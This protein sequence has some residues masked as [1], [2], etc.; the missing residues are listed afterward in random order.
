MHDSNDLNTT[1]RLEQISDLQRQFGAVTPH[2]IWPFPP[3]AFTEKQGAPRRATHGQAIRESR[4]RAQVAPVLGPGHVGP[5]HARNIPRGAQNLFGSTV[6]TNP[7]AVGHPLLLLLIATTSRATEASTVHTQPRLGSA[8]RRDSLSTV[9]PANRTRFAVS[10]TC[11][12]PTGRLPF[13]SGVHAPETPPLGKKSNISVPKYK[14]IG[15][16]YLKKIDRSKW[17]KIVIGWIVRVGE[18]SRWWRVVM[19]RECWW[20]NCY[21]L[22]QIPRAKIYY[23]LGRRKYMIVQHV[24]FNYLIVFYHLGDM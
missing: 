6:P 20:R 21:I 10:S 15:H 23:I 19:G 11:R 18:K 22:G 3:I 12:H 13:S 9:R 2:F 5:L 7:G 4:L 24:L 14:M 16:G 17:W 8:H 1:N